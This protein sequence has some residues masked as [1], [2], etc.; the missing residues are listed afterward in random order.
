[1]PKEKRD[2]LLAPPAGI[3]ELSATED[4]LRQN[5][6]ELRLKNARI[7]EQLTSSSKS[8]HTDRRFRLA[9]LN[10]MEDAEEARR[11]TEVLAAERERTEQALRESQ[12]QFRRAIEEA[13]IP[14]IMHAEDGQVLQISRTWTE[15]TAFQLG[16]M[17]TLE[18]WLKHAYGPGSGAVHERM[19]SV[20][21]DPGRS[22]ELDL[23]ITARGQ[24]RHWVFTIASPGTLRD[25]RRFAVGM[26][27]DITER[28]R[29]EEAVRQSEERM[30]RALSIETVGVVFFNLRGRITHANPAFE[31][32]SGY[33]CQELLTF[34]HWRSL[35]PPEFAAVRQR[36]AEELAERGETAPFEMQFI[37]K[38]GSRCW[39]LFAPTR[40][41]ESGLDSEC[42]EFIS[43]ITDRKR[44]EEALARSEE[45]LRL[46]IE[47]ARDYAIFS[48]DLERRV[49]AWSV[50]AEQILGYSEAEIIGKSADVI[51]VREDREAGA[52]IREAETAL[53]RGR[54]ADERWHARKDGTRFWSSGVMMAM[55]SPEG[56]TIGFV[57]I[58]RDQTAEKQ[59][60]E[61]LAAS[62]SQL[63]SALREAQTARQEAEGANRTKDAFLATL[64]HELRTPLMPVLMTI[65]SLLK[66]KELP[67]RIRDGLTMIRRNVELETRFIN[68]LLDLTRISRGK[69]ELLQELVDLHAV[70]GAAVEVC[71]PEITAKRQKLSVK[72]HARQT[73]VCGDSARLQ[74]V[75]W[76]ILKNASKFT[77]EQGEIEIDSHNEPGAIVVSIRDTGIGLESAQLPDVF[78]AFRQASV[79]VARQFGGL[80]LGL[81][82]AKATVD[83][84]GGQIWGESEGPGRGATFSVRLPLNPGKAL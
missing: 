61:A 58:L 79:E 64:S 84:L 10:L 77:S 35:I 22:V 31:Q 14:V 43:D 30:R 60:E 25:G 18:A 41:G 45:R 56:K 42:V 59:T 51:F 20:F 1:M 76:N 68:D 70:I 40:L 78:E 57:K 72:L 62:R 4:A 44:A 75:F 73:S 65:E 28:K 23:P 81:A 9:A 32:M 37:R 46:I 39:G 66:R 67:P 69:F 55:H 29:A 52:C 15:L 80:G 63:E 49:T 12:E 8:S 26:A 19:R 36:A 27:L 34:S 21:V 16:D 11:R 6:E 74:Q 2:K 48:T 7:K 38:D 47:N 3:Q 50:G 53:T 5:A 82:I 24:H 17:T 83:Q 13:P 54:A 71:Q 33:T